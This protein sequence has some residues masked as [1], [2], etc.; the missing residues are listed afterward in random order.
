MKISCILT[1]CLYSYV[2][3]EADHYCLGKGSSDAKEL[4]RVDLHVLNV[5]SS[6]GVEHSAFPPGRSV[7]SKC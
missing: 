3:Y 7:A 1:T 6:H 5:L 2:K 4:T